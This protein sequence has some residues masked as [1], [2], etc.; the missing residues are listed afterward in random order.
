MSQQSKVGKA[1][2]AG[3]GYTAGNILI[4]GLSFLALPI[5][6]RLMD[7]DQFGIYNGFIAIDSILYVITGLALHSSV[8]SAHY[9]FRG[10]TDKYVSSLSIIYLITFA[11]FHSIV[12]IFGDKISVLLGLP[13]P[14]LFMLLLYSTGSALLTLYNYRISLDYSYKKYLGLSFV[15][16]VGNIS[17]SL[18]LMLTI[19]NDSRAMGRIVGSSVTI[20][21]IAVFLLLNMWRKAK[22]KINKEYWK[23]GIKYSLPIIPHG[24]SQVLLSQFDRIMIRSLDSNASAGIYSLAGNIKIILTV[25]SESISTAWSTWFFEEIDKGNKSIIQKRATQLVWIFAFLSIGMMAIS[26]ELVLLLGGKNYESG[27][28]VAYPMIMDAFI[29][30]MYNVI[31]PSEYYM[32]KTEYIMLGTMTAA[33]IN[34]ITNYIFIKMYGFVAAAYTTLFSYICYV[35]LHLIISRKLVKF[36]IIPIKELVKMVC[37][38]GVTASID[39]LL[40]DRMFF[41]FTVNVFILGF[42]AFVLFRYLRNDGIDV[43]SLIKL[44]YLKTRT[45]I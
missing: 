15:N 32:K 30:F 24:V 35:V 20:A 11:F 39:M 10:E 33:F 18:L 42:F 34:I 8:K 43:I 2:K 25:I 6:S 4:R 19:F 3:L 12:L 22:P 5:F 37:V 21:L 29:L 7:T 44:K 45:K 9:T 28:Y 27:K 14:A 36:L 23:F 41:R 17:L 16:T 38:I 31:V 1:I 40:I 26:P 13:I